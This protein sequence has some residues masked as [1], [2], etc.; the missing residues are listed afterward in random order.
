MAG[1]HIAL[2]ADLL[3]W[4]SGCASLPTLLIA[5]PFEPLFRFRH[6]CA[7]SRD[8]RTAFPRESLCFPPPHQSALMHRS[9]FWFLFFFCVNFFW[10]WF[11]L[12]FFF[13]CVFYFWG[14][15]FCVCVCG[16]KGFLCNR[17]S[18]CFLKECFFLFAC[19]ACACPS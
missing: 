14:G 12:V 6:P 13:G 8:V 2:G 18:R 7:L 5:F 4:G 9:F 10:V 15:K 17:V 3:E 19:L 1:R 11:F 16:G